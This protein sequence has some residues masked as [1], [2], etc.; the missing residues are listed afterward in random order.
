MPQSRQGKPWIWVIIALVSLLLVSIGGFITLASR[1]RKPSP[2]EAQR[3]FQTGDY[4]S[5]LAACESLLEQE[6]TNA[7][8]LMM[9]GESASRL[10][11]YQ[12]ALDLYAAI[13]DENR[14]VAATARWAAGEV[15][16]HQKHMTAAIQ[17]MEHCLQLDPSHQG[18]RER[19]IYLLNLVGRRWDASTHLFQLLRQDQW[20][21]QHLL[22]IG[23]LAKPIEN[24]AELNE[25][26][27][28][29]ASDTLPLLG[30][31][32]IR[33]RAG[34]VAEAT[35]LLQQ[36]LQQFPQL[37]EAHV[38]MGNIWLQSQP[39]QLAAWERTLPSAAAE[40]PDTWM[41]RGQWAREDRQIP[42]ATTCF[43]TAVRIEP[44]H[45]AAL[46][47]LSQSLHALGHDEHAR[48]IAQRAAQLEKLAFQLERIM[49]DEW[50]V[51][52]SPTNSNL[53]YSQPKRIENIAAAAN[54][55]SELGRTWEAYAWTQYGLSLNA[56][57]PNLLALQQQ[58]RTARSP[59]APRTQSSLVSDDWLKSLQLPQW[60]IGDALLE[61]LAVAKTH[62]KTPNA[63]GP[64]TGPTDAFNPGS[65]DVRFDE[66]AGVLD[67]TY[68]SARD[69]FSDG[70]RMF[71]FTG[72]GVGILDYD[73]NGWPD[74]FLAQ[75][76]TW[77]FDGSDH[78]HVDQLRRNLGLNQGQVLLEN[79][80]Q[81]ARIAESAFGQGVAV[82]DVNNDGFDDVYVCNFGHNQLWLN[83]GDGTFQDAASLVP[84]TA[85]SWT[86]SAAIAD[87]NG[88]GS[89]EIY[90]AN[91]VQGADVAT[92]RCQ[93]GGMP[94][95]CAP[96][97]F[98]PAKGRL[99]MADEHGS[100]QDVS[101]DVISATC[102]EGNALGVCVFRL[103]GEKLP[104]VFIAND[105]VANIMFRTQ[106][107]PRSPLGIRLEDQ[108]VLMGLAYDNQGKA[109]ACMGVAADDFNGD[110]AI[111]LFV[112]NYYDEANTLYA[113]LP[114]ESFVD[115]SSSAGIVAPSLKMLGF[116][117]Q[118]IDAQLDGTADLLVLNG[119]I[120]DMTHM[121]TPFRMPAQ[122]LS[123]N[124]QA[125]FSELSSRTLGDY[126]QRDRLGRALAWL[127]VDCDGRQDFIATEL[128]G[129]TRLVRNVSDSGH[130]LSLRLVGTQ[131]HRDAIGAEAIITIGGRTITKQLTAGCGYMATNQRT[132]HFGCG[133]AEQI[134]Q[135]DIYWP[136]G[137]KH[138]HRD[139]PTNSHWLAVESQEQ[140][141][142]LR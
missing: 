107:D 95:A 46:N 105:Q 16:L 45:L 127:D 114:H 9:A 11:K 123:G 142:S 68:F 37:V 27:A 108:A 88:D 51:R 7:R 98:Q 31:A 22:Y 120:D 10:G 33:L 50:T 47:A 76:C 137:L 2:S 70:R 89:A 125:R 135:L 90:D 115:I 129:P 71:E 87:L 141:T 38:Q 138:T 131:S 59:R 82:G 14:Q 35:R 100:F 103:K 41:I 39:D 101:G 65:G 80:S 3:A 43:A 116:G 23:N 72:G 40:H 119:H 122:Y 96:L 5:A 20:S 111:D 53:Q 94:R 6:P 77:P 106:Q 81:A 19:L 117:T 136:S 121:G 32:K 62:N 79:V 92:R 21:P 1:P 104:S 8:Y 102:R 133:A 99:L 18:A 75:G 34:Q 134:E 112:T 78:A 109:Q 91:Y 25:F 57:E 52:R 60:P 74:M 126:F 48:T 66:S 124:R 15:A 24:E 67:F 64:Q 4:A 63:G 28:A 12:T 29:D 58:L 84:Q 73:L 54:M 110:G 128:D 113:Q 130:F 132:L 139:L 69:N 42:L 56:T 93:L 49:S 36:V 85:P 26:L 61:P 97:N 17:L 44:N 13:S 83:Q 55:T 86:A 140:L 30:I 118:A